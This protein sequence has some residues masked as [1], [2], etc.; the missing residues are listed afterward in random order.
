M[1]TIIQIRRQRITDVN[2]LIQPAG[3]RIRVQIQPDMTQTY[4][5]FSTQYA[6]QLQDSY[7]TLKTGA[8]AAVSLFTL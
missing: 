4:Y 1:I 6:T 7:S 5:L 8:Y 3:R 2:E